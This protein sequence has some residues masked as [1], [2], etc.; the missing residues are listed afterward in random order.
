LVDLL[1]EANEHITGIHHL[2]LTHVIINFYINHYE[3]V[4][5]NIEIWKKFPPCTSNTSHLL[6][7]KPIFMPYMT[8]EPDRLPDVSKIQN[9]IDV[10]FHSIGEGVK[11]FSGFQLRYTFLAPNEQHRFPASRF[12]FERMLGNRS[13]ILGGPITDMNYALYLEPDGIPVRPEWLT[14]FAFMCRW[15]N[16]EFWIK[17]SLIRG[18]AFNP[19]PDPW[20]INGNAI[21][22]FGSTAFRDFWFN[23]LLPWKKDHEPG[24]PHDTYIADYLLDLNHYFTKGR[25]VLY[26]IT[27]TEAIHNYYEGSIQQTKDRW[28]EVLI[29]H[30]A[31]ASEVATIT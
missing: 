10:T 17:G 6:N 2:Q 16:P 7:Q 5:R 25:Y 8:L 29:I 11:C 13:A 15:P 9:E 18:V 1:N 31:S 21:F 22:N 3:N 23:D 14:T 26:K 30:K 4:L 12:S 19:N 20:H 27:L 28:P 24:K